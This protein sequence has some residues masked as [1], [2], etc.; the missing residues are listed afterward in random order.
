MSP[1]VAQSRDALVHCKCPLSSAGSSD[2]CNT[3]IKSAR[4]QGRGLYCGVDPQEHHESDR[5]EMMGLGTRKSR[6]LFRGRRIRSS[7]FAKSLT[8]FQVGLVAG[9]VLGFFV[10][11]FV[12]FFVGFVG[13]FFG[14]L[15]C[16]VLGALVRPALG[17]FVDRH[18]S[19]HKL[20]HGGREVPRTRSHRPRP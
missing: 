1:V 18:S 8:G 14:L 19:L 16:L 5:K 3:G 7:V 2:R 6:L 11:L 9:L 13:L 10:G 20:N 12:S 17:L 4:E 15:V